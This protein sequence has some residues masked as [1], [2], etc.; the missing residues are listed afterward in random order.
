MPGAA[1]VLLIEKGAGLQCKLNC[2]VG[3]TEKIGAQIQLE[4]CAT[5]VLGD[6]ISIPDNFDKISELLASF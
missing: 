1:A 2:T 4:S 5:V 3:Y 6:K